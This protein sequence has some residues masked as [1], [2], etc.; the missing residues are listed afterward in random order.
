MGELRIVLTNAFKCEC[1][2]D[3]YLQGHTETLLQSEDFLCS[4]IFVELKRN[5][6]IKYCDDGIIHC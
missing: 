5:S 1:I 3:K 6:V 2:G 4:D